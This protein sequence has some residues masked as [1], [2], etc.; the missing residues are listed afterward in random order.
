MN[1][2]G[3]PKV[4]ISYSWSNSEKVI[5]LAERLMANGV[6]VILDKWDLKEGQDKYAFME[7]SVNDTTIDKVLIACDKSY[8]EKANSR[9][10]GVGDETIIT[11]PKIYEQTK[12]EKFIPIIFEIDSNGKPY[13]PTYIKSRIYID[14][15]TEDIYETNYET[16]LRNLHSK[17]LYRKPA[18]GITPEW[19]ENEKIDLSSI[20]DAIK[21]IRGCTDGND[22]KVNFLIRKC[23]S[24]FVKVLC[25]FN[26]ADTYRL[27]E[28]IL[29]QIEESKLIRDLY[30][31]FLEVI[32]YNGFEIDN[33][34]PN[35]LEQIY[36]DTHDA[37]G[38]SQYG[39]DEFEF[40]DFFI[41]ETFICT[42][43][44]LLY[45]ERFR[46]LHQILIHTYFLRDNYFV[47]TLKTNNF[48]TFRKYFKTI[49][50]VCKPKSE[51]LELY[52]LA[53]DI[54]I[55]REKKPLL[56]KDS[57]ANADIVLYQMSCILELTKDDRWHWFP[58][59][60]P[61]SRWPQPIWQKLESISYCEKI[62]PLFGVSSVSAL[63]EKIN[64]AKF[65][66]NIRYSNLFDCAP[67]IYNSIKIENIA[68][69]N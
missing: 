3:N 10:G 9:E 17:P 68:T 8:T 32:I 4:F 58:I 46:E 53:G 14:L 38:K 59:L 23:I 41:W 66:E 15:S 69:L 56:T 55:K 65:G 36:N 34:I 50:D 20:R 21:Q 54:L 7:Q 16:L 12:Q 43:S 26:S 47:Q 30:I 27:N 22:T 37:S 1:D 13:C 64:N 48:L 42:T 33:I 24:E 5:E 57:I 60:Y 35:F 6:E 31:E 61:Y 19:L 52:T 39:E 63:K 67:T 29:K 51:N 2:K 62:M 18:L 25:S 40:F 11:S 28:V 49:E 44:T 45:Y